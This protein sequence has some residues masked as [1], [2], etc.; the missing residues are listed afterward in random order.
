MTI[1]S[2]KTT[3]DANSNNHIVAIYGDKSLTLRFDRKRSA[4]QNHRSA[5][6][7]LKK[8][9]GLSGKM[10]GAALP[11]PDE[12]LWIVLPKWFSGLASYSEALGGSAVESMN[13]LESHYKAQGRQISA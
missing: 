11:S 4:E 8:K 6:T 5:A 3:H 1:N 9:M 10:R 7:L 2:I 13:V 12:R